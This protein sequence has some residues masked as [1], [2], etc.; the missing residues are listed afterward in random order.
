MDK[1]L[2]AQTRMGGLAAL[3]L[4]LVVGLSACGGGGATSASGSATPN[5]AQATSSGAI[6]AFGSVFVNGHE[7]DTSQ[8]QW[9]NDDTGVKSAA[10]ILTGL[11]VGM[12][13]DVDQAPSSSASAPVAQ[14]L[15]LH[16]LARGY[17]DAID[18]TAGTLS[19]MGQSVQLNASTVYS[20]HRACV[21][22]T[23]STC[24]A[25]TTA[26]G[27][28]ATSG[29]G[30]SAVPGSYVAVH[31]YLFGAGST[32]SIVANLV[33]VNDVQS[34]PDAFKAEGPATLSS[35]PSLSI[36]GLAVDLSA[37]KCTSNG[38]V[39]PCASA[40]S[41]GAVVAVGAASAPAL[42]ASSF[43]ASWARS[44]ARVAVDSAGSPVEVEGMVSSVSS[45]PASF[46]LRGTTVDAS[47]LPLSSLPA[48]GDKVAVQGV[49]AASGTTLTA[50]SIKIL[51]AAASAQIGLEGD[52]SAITSVI[53][54]AAGSAPSYTLS[55]LGKTI[56]VTAQTQLSDQSQ[57]RLFLEQKP[58]HNPFN[59]KT[60]ASYLSAQGESQ[61][62]IVKATGSDANGWL[63]QTLTIVPASSV[64]AVEGLVDATPAPVNSAT[65]G[66]PSTF[67]VQGIAISA[68]PKS[69][70]APNKAKMATV[71]AGDQVVAVGSWSGAA[72]TVTATPGFNNAV[73]D[74][75]A[76]RTQNPQD[77][78][79]NSR[80]EF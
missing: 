76:P 61:H 10:G 25:V 27:L 3:A 78:Q 57:P 8:A 1:R 77:Q 75:G 74:A 79:G 18:T 35:A 38:S 19:V 29:S 44:A 41:N 59:I 70:S 65:S 73:F 7:F 30:G 39:S 34:G 67:S 4:G 17:V 5:M 66:T 69:I 47:N 43:A 50:S 20:D 80:G 32:S 55:L 49:L 62:L 40:F 42:P 64:V 26:S 60:F 24:T 53:P 23:P 37:A 16:P 46:V 58:D 28:V 45:A 15:H 52:A 6:S 63:A 54:S 48:V 12:V 72:V 11:E 9:V 14:L 2:L 56:T 68:D 13:V 22:A 21:S 51:H 31:G 36:G 71:S 33:V